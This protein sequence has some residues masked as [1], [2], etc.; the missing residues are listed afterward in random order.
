MTRL[1]FFLFVPF[2]YSRQPATV[3]AC[4][5]NN[6]LI[7]G[8]E[9]PLEASIENA[10][11]SSITLSTD[12]GTITH[13]DRPNKF[14]IIPARMGETQIYVYKKKRLVDSV[15]FRVKRLPPPTLFVGIKSEGTIKKSVTLIQGGVIAKYENTDFEAP[16][17][18]VDYR[19]FLIRDAAFVGMS[20]NVG[21]RFNEKTKF[22]I[23]Q[24]KTGDCLLFTSIHV[25]GVDGETITIVSRDYTI[26]E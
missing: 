25:K 22:L 11:V 15:V 7:L 6:I 21:N 8:V 3:I 23:E 24:S 16:V 17:K 12:N 14:V 2:I 20:L 1:I 10:P 19:V 18:V 4:T 9:N 13:G 5:R 26:I